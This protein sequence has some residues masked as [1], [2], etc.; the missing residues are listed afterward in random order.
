MCRGGRAFP[1]PLLC[2]L[3]QLII[4]RSQ[5]CL[6]GYLVLI[7]SQP[8]RQFKGREGQPIAAAFPLCG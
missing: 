5:E 4:A 8:S 6:Y 7:Y 2:P 1:R 3:P